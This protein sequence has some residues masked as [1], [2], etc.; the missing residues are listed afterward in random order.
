MNISQSEKLMFHA[1]KKMFVKF[2]VLSAERRSGAGLSL[3]NA[4]V[5]A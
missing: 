3:K 4:T 1:A 5:Q 2:H